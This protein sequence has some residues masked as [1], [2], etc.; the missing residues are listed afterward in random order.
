MNK[1]KKAP[2]KS[3]SDEN[4]GP[5]DAQVM[6][7]IGNLAESVV[8]LHRISAAMQIQIDELADS[9]DELE[10][11]NGCQVRTFTYSR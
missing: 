6:E 1:T 5:T 9:I 11:G 2:K 7:M 3:N 4:S 10:N 8:R